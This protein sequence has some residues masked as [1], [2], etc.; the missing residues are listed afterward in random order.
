MPSFRILKC[1]YLS[2]FVE[3]Y[4]SNKKSPSC[5]IPHFMCPS[6]YSLFGCELAGTLFHV[7]FHSGVQ[8]ESAVP[9][10]AI[11]TMKTQKAWPVTPAS[12]CERWQETQLSWGQGGRKLHPTMTLTENSQTLQ[13]HPSAVG[14]LNT[15]SGAELG[16]TMNPIVRYGSW[17]AS[18]ACCQ[19]L[20][21]VRQELGPALHPCGRCLR[22]TVL[23]L[24]VPGFGSWLHHCGVG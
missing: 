4:C 13:D 20:S 11:F 7:S 8:T 9:T 23:K 10:V 15:E 24:G 17:P 12:P 1:V 22:E 16:K 2:V 6:D 18:P 19:L 5:T 21:V 14:I 3:V